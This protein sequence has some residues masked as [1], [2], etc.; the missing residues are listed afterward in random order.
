[1]NRLALPL[2][3][4]LICGCSAPRPSTAR[5]DA[6]LSG[7]TTA[8]TAADAARAAQKA[9]NTGVI[10][11]SSNIEAAPAEPEEPEEPTSQ[12]AEPVA[13][14]TRLEVEIVKGTATMNGEPIADF[15]TVAADAVNADPEVMLVITAHE[16]VAQEKLNE[17]TTAAKQAG[18]KRTMIQIEVSGVPPKPAT[19]ADLKDVDPQKSKP[20][21]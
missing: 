10:V 17:L 13:E 15:A 2:A 7:E 19:P 4:A 18:I 5:P 20:T 9:N 8:K 16:V 21:P 12:P 1:M 14:T 3:I 6:V 11:A